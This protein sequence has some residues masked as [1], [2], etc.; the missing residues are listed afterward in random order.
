MPPQMGVPR[1]HPA[2]FDQRDLGCPTPDAPNVPARLPARPADIALISRQVRVAKHPISQV[3]VLDVARL[4]GDVSQDL[5]HAIQVA[6]A[7]GPRAVV[8]DLTALSDGVDP[9]ALEVLAT[10]GRHV[11]DWPGIPVAMACPDRQVREALAAHAMG[12][13]LTMTQSLSGALSAVS[14]VPNMAVER[15]RLSPHPTAPRASR[16]F[17]TRTLLDWRLGRAIH[18]ASLVAG[19]LV[20]SS[21]THAG[22]DIEVCIVWDREGLRLSVRDYR[23]VG[24]SFGPRDLDVH[25]RL[26][27]VLAGL[28]RSFGVL[29]TADGG[30]VVWAVFDASPLRPGT[31]N[32]TR[33][34]KQLPATGTDIVRAT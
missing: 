30:K 8:C 29:P 18:F 6:L 22:T 11:R 28:S 21:S 33:G 10:A 12:R 27:I 23:P 34:Y 31:G 3:V 9:G 17:V 14:S 24:S 1:D 19:V 25:G 7:E 5:D 13:Y 15:L 32:R 2:D 16:D 20:A 26:L 4:L